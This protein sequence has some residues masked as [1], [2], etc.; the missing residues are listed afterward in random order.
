MKQTLS[1][2]LLHTGSYYWPPRTLCAMAL[3]IQSTQLTTFHSLHF[4]IISPDSVLTQPWE[5]NARG[6][7]GLRG[8]AAAEPA[9]AGNPGLQQHTL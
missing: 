3:I 4:P 2:Y 5:Q 9:L 7:V 6:R 1:L 8:A